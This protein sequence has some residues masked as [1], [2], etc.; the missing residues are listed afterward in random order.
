MTQDI[1]LAQ[2]WDRLEELVDQQ[3]GAELQ[4]F[5]RTLTSSELARAVSRMDVEKQ[6]QL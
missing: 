2:P 6:Q 4:L 3:N 5:W 1:Q